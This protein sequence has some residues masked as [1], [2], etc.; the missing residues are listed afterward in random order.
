M[1]NV[2]L[3][4]TMSTLPTTEQ[5]GVIPMHPLAGGGEMPMMLMGGNDFSGWFKTVGPGAGIQTFFSYGNAEQIAPQL[6]A[7][8]RDK[9]FVSTGIPCGCCGPD[10]PK[11]KPMNATTAEW[12]ID[13]ELA[14]LR[15]SFA[16]LLLFHHRCTTESET[17]AVWSALEAA[18]RAGKARHI[19]CGS[20]TPTAYRL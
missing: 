12:Y 8:G 3:V 16:D 9:V 5:N 17:A 10:T 11:F 19:V 7:A 2:V 15:T 6:E 14:K 18:K 1:I 13:E 4:A 20:Q